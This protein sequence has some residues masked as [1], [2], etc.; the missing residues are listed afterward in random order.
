MEFEVIVEP[1]FLIFIMLNFIDV[2]LKKKLII[3]MIDD[4][5]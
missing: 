4:V 2:G 5:L 1:H 3:S